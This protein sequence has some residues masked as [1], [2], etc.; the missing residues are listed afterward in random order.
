[1]QDVS[2]VSND[3][4]TIFKRYQ[5]VTKRRDPAVQSHTST[6]HLY[7]HTPAHHSCTVTHHHTAAVQ[8]HTSTSQLYSHTPEH[9]RCTV[10]HQHIAAVQSH[11]ST[12]QLYNHT[13]VH[14]RIS[15]VRT[16][17]L[18][19]G[20]AL[21][22]RTHSGSISVFARTASHSLCFGV[23]CQYFLLLLA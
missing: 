20:S 22:L 7:S 4:E 18:A 3:R 17:N 13:P 16:S 23:A 21:F 9:P 2:D 11:T 14:P 1:M 15:A 19:L 8:S 10:T 6:S 5:S 12:S